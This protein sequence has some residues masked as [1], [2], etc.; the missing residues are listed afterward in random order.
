MKCAKAIQV[1]CR[2]SFCASSIRLL[3]RLNS[4]FKCQLFSNGDQG[5]PKQTKKIH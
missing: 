5:H 4:S 3:E 1:I 2:D